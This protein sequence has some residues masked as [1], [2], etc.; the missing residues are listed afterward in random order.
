MPKFASAVALSFIAIAAVSPA[1]PQQTRPTLAQQKMCADQADEFFRDLVSPSVPRRQI[2]PLVAS[3]VNHYDPQSNTCYVAIT[4]NQPSGKVLVHSTTVFDA[5]EG[6]GYAS[7]T[8]TS[9]RVT[10][11]TPV[12]PPVLCAIEPRGQPKVT[13]KSEDEFDYL[14][15]RYFGA[16][17]R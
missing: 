2:D 17:V 3:Y 5:F 7:Y 4:R 8:Q 16:I 9:D 6:T 10:A 12:Q 15:E 13:C 1:Q 14:V 11:G